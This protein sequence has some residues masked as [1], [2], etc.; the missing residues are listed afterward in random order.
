MPCAVPCKSSCLKKNGSY[1]RRGYVPD[2]R[3]LG[4]RFGRG[5][6]AAAGHTNKEI[7]TKLAVKEHTVAKLR[8]RF[9]P[10]GMEGLREQGGRG[11]ERLY[12]AEKLEAIVRQPFIP[13]LR[14][15]RTGARAPSPVPVE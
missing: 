2:V 14:G 15:R 6:C 8:T 5:S 9:V 10:Q 11:R 13:S 1:G 12:P 4:T 7:S 3:P